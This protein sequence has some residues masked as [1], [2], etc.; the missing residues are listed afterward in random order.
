MA[1]GLK[2]RRLRG[3]ALLGVL[4]LLI[5]G[6]AVSTGSLAQSDALPCGSEQHKAFDFFAGEWQVYDQH[7]GR[8][9]AIDRIERQLENCSLTQSW[10]Q[11]DDGFRTQGVPYR[12]Q[13]SSLIGYDGKEWVMVWIDNMGSIISLRGGI[14]DGAMVMASDKP[15]LG[16]YYMWKWIPQADGTLRNVGYFA[17]KE[18]DPWKEQFDIIY[19]PNRPAD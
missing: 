15:S 11:M 18:D 5:A 1:G 19:K 4:S 2:V 3:L 7:S 10:T 14:E 8:L 17:D 9:I 13:G 6:L 16:T 12:M